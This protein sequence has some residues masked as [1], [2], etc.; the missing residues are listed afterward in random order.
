M[1]AIK[2]L[3]ED[4]H[5]V[6]D[7]LERLT[8]TTSRAQKKRTELLSKITDELEVHTQIENEIFYPA[9]KKAGEKSEDAKMYFEARE[10]HRV[11]ELVLPDLNRTAVDSE[12]FSGRAKVLRELVEHHASEE[13]HDMFPRA[14]KL[15]SK[16]ELQS[17]GE[18]LQARKQELMEHRS[19][20]PRRREGWASAPD[21]DWQPPMAPRQPLRSWAS[22]MRT[23]WEASPE[24][25]A[26]RWTPGAWC[27]A[28]SGQAAQHW[29]RA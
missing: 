10:E 20:P 4:H 7:P 27:A 3:K 28:R 26:A 14:R 22:P 5:K 19:A 1:D 12:Q 17:L 8:D 24:R 15:M 23:R 18:Q 6:K 13:E 16:D 21:D 11:G 9:F 25:R 2:L 29:R